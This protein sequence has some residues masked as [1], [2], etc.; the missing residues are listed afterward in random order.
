MASFSLPPIQDNPDGSWGPSAFNIPDQFKFKDIPYAPYSKADKLGRFADWN[1][2]SSDN[3]QN[4]AG[5][6]STQTNRPG[7]QNR[8]REGVQAYGSGTA[9]AFTYQHADDESS[10]SLVDNK[11]T[12]KYQLLQLRH[13]FLY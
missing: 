4:V 2:L 6:P 13:T 11:A 7:A 8:R 1:D 5:L 3:R 10:F 12:M 9:S